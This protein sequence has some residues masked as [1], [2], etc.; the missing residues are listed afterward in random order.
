[1]DS[2]RGL[3]QREADFYDSFSNFIDI[4]LKE[5]P[6]FVIH[7]GDLFDSVRPSNRAISFALEQVKRLSDSGIGFVAISGNHETPRLRE[8]GSVF[9]ILDHLPNCTFVY[10]GRMRR[11]ERDGVEIIAFPHTTAELFREELKKANGFKKENPRLVLFH[12][13]L[14]GIGVFR[15][16]E[17]NE[18]ILD[19]SNLDPDADYIA[20]GH[21]H[22]HIDVS[23]TCSYAGSTERLSISEAGVA[24]GFVDLDLPSRKRRFVP[25]PTRKMIDIASLN[26]S[27]C[28]AMDATSEI[29]RALESSGIDEAIARISVTGLRKDARKDLDMNRIRRTSQRALSLELVFSGKDDDQLIQNEGAHIGQLEEEFSRFIDAAKL[30]GL[31]RKRVEKEAMAL[32][33]EKDE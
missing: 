25:L 22:N 21:Y 5:R 19:G 31:D 3:N 20:L 30:G 2:E 14:L 23:R 29:L 18:L 12:A 33:A 26:L 13:G 16:N 1:M 9:R 11:I 4:A 28:N 8:T 17:I 10:D 7:S 32:F 27:S 15:M 24:K 6:D